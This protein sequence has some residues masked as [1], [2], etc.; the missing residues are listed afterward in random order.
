MK[1]VKNELF[2]EFASPP[3]FMHEIDP[4]YSGLEGFAPSQ[5]SIDVCRW[6]K[7]ERTRQAS[8]RRSLS[9]QQRESRDT[10]IVHNLKQLLGDVV[11]QVVGAGWPVCGAPDIIASLEGFSTIGTIKFLQT[12]AVSGQS[13]ISHQGNTGDRFV[14]GQQ[15]RLQ[16][17]WD[18]KVVPDVIIV[19]VIGFDKQNYRLGSGKGLIEDMILRMAQRP[20][21]FGVGYSFSEV[22]TI[23]PQAHDIVMDVIITEHGIT[24]VNFNDKTG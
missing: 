1:K 14:K 21:L 12:G 16:L 3:C 6:R 24:T 10:H 17:S 9:P 15:D 13:L 7:A 22:P 2:G 18:T 8:M 19:P 20:R 4:A 23:Y 5:Q 11:G